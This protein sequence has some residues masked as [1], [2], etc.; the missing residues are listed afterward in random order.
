MKKVLAITMVLMLVFSVSVM[1]K[2]K[3]KIAGHSTSSGSYL[4]ARGLGIGLELG[5]P[6]GLNVK[7]WV[8]SDSA[9]QFD[10]S[11]Y[12]GSSISVGAAYLIHFFDVIEVDDNK[13]PL[14]FGIKGSV[15]IGS[16]IGVAIQVPLGISWIPRKYPIDVFL[17]FEPGISVIPG[18]GPVAGG[19]IGIRYWLD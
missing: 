9:V 16:T 19:Y 14:Y 4:G 8:S 6:C 15:G 18:V 3:I 10:A 1:A 13:L 2:V 7:S 5:Y 11:W 12:F 17:Q